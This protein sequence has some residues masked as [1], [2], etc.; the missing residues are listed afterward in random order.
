ML[1]VLILFIS[2]FFT[3]NLFAATAEQ[4]I[5]DYMSDSVL[6]EVRSI[7]GER[8]NL[9][10]PLAG[11]PVTPF[12]RMAPY[13]YADGVSLPVDRDINAREISNQFFQAQETQNYKNAS[14]FLWLWGQFMD[15]DI[16]LTDV[17]KEESMDIPVPKCDRYFDL[18]CTGTNKMVFHRSESVLVNGV[19]EQ[20]NRTTSY[21]D[22]SMVYGADD[23]RAQTLRT[24]DGTGKM[25]L[26]ENGY[27]PKNIWGLQNLPSESPH[28]FAAGDI[29]ANDHI[30]LM[31][32]HNL[33]V[34]EHNYWAGELKAAN[35]EMSGEDLYQKARAIVIAEIQNITFNE[36][37]PILTGTYAPSV[38]SKY[39]E[40]LKA[41]VF[42]EFSTSAFRMGHTLVSGDFYLENPEG[43]AFFVK[44][45]DSFFNPTEYGRSGLDSIMLGF[46]K[47]V[48]Q[49]RDPMI[50]EE[51]QNFLIIFPEEGIF[52]LF[53]F[54]L[55]RGR[56]HGIPSYN[57]LREA[58]GFSRVKEFNEIS[59]YGDFNLSMSAMYPT[60]DDIDPW[61]GLIAEKASNSA[62][63]GA[64][65]SNIIA[66]QFELLRDA[67]RFWFTNTYEDKFV[68]AIKAQTLSKI[69]V[70][71]SRIS[72][73]QISENAFIVE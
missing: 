45:R 50:N 34:R 64:T 38:D 46:S 59:D 25:I 14:D 3:Q 32:I 27:L 7:T 62:L 41:A 55:Q 13:D 11:T 12:I 31:A 10:D 54:N 24:M 4:S 73:D 19:R 56:D 68:D 5:L 36:F 52:D 40:D 35:P 9:K 23:V 53:A 70:R 16:T 20:V 42:S 51:L 18:S 71:N 2:L 72:A 60:V 33:F 57:D 61:L 21:V 49:E 43:Q 37:L 6:T 47:H 8:V 69:I 39:D 48:A 26:D 29:R 22:G 17:N 15:H 63:L 67:D 65:A 30:G 66:R 1:R 58:V 44:L 28:F